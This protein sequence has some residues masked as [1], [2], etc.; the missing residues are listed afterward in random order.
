MK[1][2][3]Y[4]L[5]SPELGVGG[6]LLPADVDALGGIV[7]IIAAPVFGS[8]PLIFV[9]VRMVGPKK[10]NCVPLQ[11]D[12]VQLI[13]TDK[14]KTKTVFRLKAG[15][16]DA[17]VVEH[18]TDLGPGHRSPHAAAPCTIHAADDARL[19]GQQDVPGEPGIGIAAG[20]PD[21]AG[22]VDIV[23]GRDIVVK[24]GGIIG[25]GRGA[26]IM[27]NAGDIAPV[28]DSCAAGIYNTSFLLLSCR[29]PALP[30]EGSASA[31]L[32]GRLLLPRSGTG[33]GMS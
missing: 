12:M 13:V 33:A 16:A 23:P 8:D 29:F 17:R 3:V 14:G 32:K 11:V 10:F 27:I 28:G 4:L 24:I 5:C 20:N 1:R 26:N 2:V 6:P 7:D 18:L 15:F 9:R 31:R 19:V 30:L 21:I 22:I 25:A